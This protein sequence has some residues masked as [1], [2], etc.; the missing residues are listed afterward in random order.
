MLRVLLAED[1][2]PIREVCARLVAGNS[3]IVASVGTGDDAVTAADQHHPDVVVLDV[4]MPGIGGI[5]A[6]CQIKARH[7]EI[8][9]VFISSHT[10]GQYIA[11]AREIGA[12]GYVFK[13]R[14]VQDLQAALAA[15][16]SKSFFVSPE[17][18]SS[19]ARVHFP[20]AR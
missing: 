12:G 11:A 2:I 9:I 19:V 14:L 16:V 15:A 5:E 7:P 10:A 17:P 4:T 8:A 1:Y 13:H 3:E 18:T 20:N 6:A